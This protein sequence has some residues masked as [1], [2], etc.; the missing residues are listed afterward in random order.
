MTRKI[1]TATLLGLALLGAVPAEAG[2]SIGITIS[3]TKGEERRAINQFL[4]F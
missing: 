2:G 4:R 1:L 3:A